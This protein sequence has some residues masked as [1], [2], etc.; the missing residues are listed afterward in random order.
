[1]RKQS[2]IRAAKQGGFTLIELIIVIVIIGILAAVAV[3]KFLG[4]SD[5]A[6]ASK[7]SAILGALKSAYS[8]EFAKTH[9]T[10]TAAGIAGQ[11]ADPTCT[12]AFACTGLTATITYTVNTANPS[13]ADIVCATNAAVSLSCG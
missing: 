9:T 4:V 1:M 5:E 6:Q 13:P 10:P 11:M 12:S 8:V 7:N 3:P 2:S